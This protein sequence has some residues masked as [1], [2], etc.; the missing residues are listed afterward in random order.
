MTI[1]S[2]Y[3]RLCKLKAEFVD[4]III[5][6]NINTLYYFTGYSTP[7]NAFTA[8]LV[9][10]NGY[11]H[12]VVRDLESTNFTD[13]ELKKYVKLSTYAEESPIEHIVHLVGNCTKN[14]ALEA[15]DISLQ[16]FKELQNAIPMLQWNDISNYTTKLR[17]IKTKSEQ[18]WIR[19]AAKY[20]QCGIQAASNS[21]HIGMS[22]THL[23]GVIAEASMKAG[24]EWTAYPIFVASGLNGLRGHHAASNEK[25]IQSGELVFIEVGASHCRYHAARMHTMYMGTPPAWF[26][27]IEKA[28]RDAL[29]LARIHAIPGVRGHELDTIMRTAVNN[30]L[31]SNSTDCSELIPPFQML[32]RSGYSIGC[33]ISRDWSD[34]I[35]YVNPTSDYILEQDMVLHIIPWLQIEHKGAIGFSDTVIVTENGGCSVFTPAC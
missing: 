4:H 23:S 11:M 1:E 31:L 21:V 3:E 22:E 12:F 26:I 7:G 10:N 18:E 32:R 19:Q 24:C 35:F 33:S 15:S 16:H 25:C 6:T 13:Q 9:D 29:E 14:I 2:K 30:A 34:G 5:L 27:A 8:L 17:W 20:V 28:L